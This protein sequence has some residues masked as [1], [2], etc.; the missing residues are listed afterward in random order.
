MQKT[1]ATLQNDLKKI[2]YKLATVESQTTRIRAASIH[3]AVA[4]ATLARNE[5]QKQN[6]K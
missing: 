1:L 5:E 6:L 2:Q 4:V 3:L